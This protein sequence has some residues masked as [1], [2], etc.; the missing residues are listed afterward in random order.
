MAVAQ[1]VQ[2]KGKTL[3]L[4]LHAPDPAPQQVVSQHRG[5]RHSQTGGGHDQGLAHGRGNLRQADLACLSDTQQGK[6][7]QNLE[8]ED[9][10]NFDNVYLLNPEHAFELQKQNF[11]K[12][13]ISHFDQQY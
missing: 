8:T 9:F 5:N 13:M 10:L 2:I 11:L 7:I 6:E 3:Q 1:R 4:G 12:P